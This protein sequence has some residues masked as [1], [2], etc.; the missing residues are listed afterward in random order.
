MWSFSE[1]Y[2]VKDHHFRPWCCSFEKVTNWFLDQHLENSF[3]KKNFN[4][5]FGIQTRHIQ[6]WTSTV[7]LY[8]GFY[9]HVGQALYKKFI[10]ILCWKL[11]KKCEEQVFNTMTLIWIVQWLLLRVSLKH[12]LIPGMTL[13]YQNLAQ[14]NPLKVPISAKPLELFQKF[15]RFGTVTRP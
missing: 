15:N 6:N 1:Y 12:K 14:N 7:D 11:A 13:L 8:N 3:T 4:N 2:I 9:T 10:S 5:S